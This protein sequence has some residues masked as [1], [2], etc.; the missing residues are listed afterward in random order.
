MEEKLEQRPRDLVR[1]V[2]YGPE[3]TGKTTLAQGLAAHFNTQWVPEFSRDY[4]QKKWDAERRICGTEDMLPIAEGQM[5]LENTL[6]ASA[7]ELLVLDTNLMESVVYSRAYFN[8]YVDS[9]LLK[10]A[11]KA[12]YDLYLLTYIDVPWEADDLRDKPQEREA[13]FDRFR[14]TLEQYELPYEVIKGTYQERLE[15]AVAIIEKLL[16]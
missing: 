9:L 14:D 12:N 4:L 13:M 10:Q 15:L 6:A 11:L 5:Q 1:V 3:S 7:E 8:G 2:L 16:Q